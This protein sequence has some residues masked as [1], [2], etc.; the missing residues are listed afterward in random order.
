MPVA[1]PKTGEVVAKL[2]PSL[3]A[4]RILLL[5]LEKQKLLREARALPI[6][7]QSLALEG[8]ILLL[9]GKVER[10]I[11]AI[12]TSLAICPTDP[13]TWNNFSSALSNL[14]L[15]SKR[16]ELLTRAL[17]YDF[18]CMAEHALNFAAF[19]ADGEILD[20]AIAKLEKF[21]QTEKE[22][23]VSALQ[24]AL[25]LSNLGDSMS[26]GL[27]KAADVLMYIVESESLRAKTSSLLTDGDG[28]ASFSVGIETEDAEY[29]SYLN[30][31]V[32]DEM[33][34]R[35]LETGCSV[36]YFEAVN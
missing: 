12:E 23:N 3:E 13:V 10:G 5:D 17:D 29:L 27:K 34:E 35:G 2:G 1:Q 4:G 31:K 8:L 36:A 7:Y 9:D 21:G 28:Y 32:V 15:Y 30:D 22:T 33:I 16:R 25:V 19:W 14:G 6:R 26:D 11:E 20:M 24:T 18:P